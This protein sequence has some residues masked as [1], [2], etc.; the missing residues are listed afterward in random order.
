MR[1]AIAE[2]AF[3]QSG[4]R[5]PIPEDDRGL[6]SGIGSAEYT[7]TG[8]SY[9]PLVCSYIP[10]R[11][12][13]NFRF[14]ELCILHSGISGLPGRRCFLTLTIPERRELYNDTAGETL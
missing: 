12:Q 1:P 3:R 2:L 11:P 4:Q 7:R 6:S 10:P 9:S 8:E 5:L 14:P 13:A